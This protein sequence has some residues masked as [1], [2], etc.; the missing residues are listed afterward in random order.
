[1][2]APAAVYSS[3]G[4]REP[5]PAP[6]WI[7]TWWPAETRWWAPA[8]VNATRYSWFLTSEGTPTRMG[9]PFSLKIW[10]GRTRAPRGADATN[11]YELS[12]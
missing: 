12:R 6:A 7:I 2:V 4:I 8:G 11:K 10:H 1:M 5:A 3:S 9:W